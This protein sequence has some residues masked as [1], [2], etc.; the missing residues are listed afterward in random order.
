[1]CCP[2]GSPT[3]STRAV[4]SLSASAAGPTTRA[5]SR[6][7]SLVAHS[8]CSRAG[9]S[10]RLH[11]IARSLVT[12]PLCTPYGIAGRIASGVTSA[13]AVPC[14]HTGRRASGVAARPPMASADCPRNLR[15]FMGRPPL[16]PAER[17]TFARSLRRRRGEP[18]RVDDDAKDLGVVEKSSDAL[19]A[20]AHR[21]QHHVLAGVHALRGAVRE[22]AEAQNRAGRVLVLRVGD[23]GP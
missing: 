5:A 22:V 14:A 21:R 3:R 18:E 8:T 23:V 2:A 10:V 4:K 16:L 1:M 17:I 15:R 13:G 6:N 9:R 11:T 19:G 20:R 7:E 12:S